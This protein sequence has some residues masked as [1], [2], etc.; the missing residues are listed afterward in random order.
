MCQWNWLGRVKLDCD[1]RSP[2]CC[3]TH[4][5]QRGDY[6]RWYY[7]FRRRPIPESLH[8]TTSKNV[9]VPL[10]KSDTSPAEINSVAQNCDGESNQATLSLMAE[11][12]TCTSTIEERPNEVQNEVCVFCLTALP[13]RAQICAQFFFELRWRLVTFKYPSAHLAED[14]KI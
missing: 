3:P 1:Y 7:E 8:L 9:T 6:I 10:R 13:L 12:T 11:D 2:V 5:R 4:N 14:I